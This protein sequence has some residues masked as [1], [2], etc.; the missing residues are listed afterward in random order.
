MATFPGATI[1]QVNNKKVIR[2][3]IEQAPGDELQ[4]EGEFSA[5]GLQNA[6]RHSLVTINDSGWTALPATPLSDRNAI[7]IQNNSN[8]DIK[9]NF[10]TSV[11]FVGMTIKPGA[12]RTY[13]IKD[14]ILI[15][16]RSFSGNVDIDVEELS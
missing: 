16:G 14:T 5:S 6:G 1:D 13:D 8:V 4:I 9:V 2:T 7:A 10:T 11:G 12:E 15:Y 3:K